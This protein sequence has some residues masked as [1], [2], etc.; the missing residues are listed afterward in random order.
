M[1]L[2]ACEVLH[3]HP[4]SHLLCYR[5]P[6]KWCSVESVCRHADGTV[7]KVK[8]SYL[9]LLSLPRPCSVASL[10]FVVNAPSGLLAGEAVFD[11]AQLSALDMRIKT[12]MLQVQPQPWDDVHKYSA[13][14]LLHI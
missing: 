11:A 8:P 12:A 10:L 2:M 3:W 4:D 5:Q 1:Q 14:T 9:D 13:R 7:S 6:S